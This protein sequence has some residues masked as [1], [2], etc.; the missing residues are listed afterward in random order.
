MVA[1]KDRKLAEL[2][3]YVA[4]R[5]EADRFFG[6][7]KLNKILF[8][9][10]FLF[11][12][13]TGRSITGQEYQR[14]PNGPAPRRLV[15]VRDALEKAGDLALRTR[16]VGGLKQVRAIAIREADLSPFSGEEIAM[17]DFVIEALRGLT[18]AESS[19]LSHAELGWKLAEEGETI[20][21]S[22][23]FLSERKITQEEADFAL[24]LA[25]L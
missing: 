16:F 23:V 24:Q 25:E 2:I 8:Y 10:D 13:K 1:K 7:I 22:T 19:E 3:L 18:A 17:V 12:Q 4:E 5:S 21:Y 6:A 9:A 15:P 14:L 11:H 20:P